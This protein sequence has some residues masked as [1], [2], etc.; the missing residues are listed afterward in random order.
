MKKLTLLLVSLL[1][2]SVYAQEKSTKQVFI[3]VVHNG[4]TIKL[5]RNQNKDNKISSFYL[6]TAR[7]KIQSMHPFALHAVETIGELD[8]INYIKKN[9]QAMIPS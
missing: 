6:K 8:M 5:Q 9:Q 3:E 7:G 4:K 2:L 1:T